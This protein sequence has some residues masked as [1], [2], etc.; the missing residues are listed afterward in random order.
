MFEKELE[1]FA[2]KSLTKEEL[3]IQTATDKYNK[4]LA[5]ADQYGLDSVTLTNNYE[6][7]IKGIRRDIEILQERGKPGDDKKIKILRAE[8]TN[9]LNK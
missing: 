8:L 2:A 6:E 5:I 1:D 4:L 9:L 3:E 7:Q